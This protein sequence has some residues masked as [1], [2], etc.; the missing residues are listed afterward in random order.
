MRYPATFIA[1]LVIPVS[2]IAHTGPHAGTG[3]V[4]AIAHLP[5]QHYA[6]QLAG[7]CI[8]A[9]LF[10]AGFRVRHGGDAPEPGGVGHRQRRR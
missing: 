1:A 9:L 6:P 8:A 7:A 3:P 2:A 5:G 4:G 10:I